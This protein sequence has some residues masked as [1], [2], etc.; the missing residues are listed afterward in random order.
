M[1]EPLRLELCAL[2]ERMETGD[3]EDRATSIILHAAMGAERFGNLP[4]LVGL[5]LKFSAE[6]LV[7]IKRAREALEGTPN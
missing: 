2:A 1:T 6:T 3:P 7:E 4:K 5:C